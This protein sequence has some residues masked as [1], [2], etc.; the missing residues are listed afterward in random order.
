MQDQLSRSVDPSRHLAYTQ[1]QPRNPGNLHNQLIV[2]LGYFI[3]LI[4]RFCLSIVF[5]F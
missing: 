2:Y 1:Q 3:N 5:I 4:D